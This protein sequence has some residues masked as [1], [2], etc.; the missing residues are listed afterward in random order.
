MNNCPNC[1]QSCNNGDCGCIPQGL[2]TPNYCPADLPTCPDPSPCNETFDSNC[3][4][5]TG[6]DLPC[7]N[8]STD[9]TVQ[10]AIQSIAGALE[11]FFC[12]ECIT[13]AVPANAATNVPV[14][15]AF[16][17]NMVPGATCYDVYLGTS[18]TSLTL[19]SL[20]QILTTYTHPT[21]LLEG[22][23]YYWQVVPRN[24]AGTPK[25][26]CP[27]YSFTTF[28][29]E[30]VNPMTYFLEQL[31]SLGVTPGDIGR[32]S[33]SLIAQ[34]QLLTNCNLCCPDCTETKRYVLAS[35][36]TYATYYSAVYSPSCLPPCCVE[37]DSALTTYV[38]SGL[39]TIFETI[40]P[41]T[42]CCGTNFSECSKEIKDIL[43]ADANQV[44]VDYGIV[45]ESTFNGSTT[46]CILANYLNNLPSTFTT[47]DKVDLL[48]SIL[49]G[50][51]VI[52]CRP[53]GTIITTVQGYIDYLTAVEID[54]CFCYKPCEII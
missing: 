51:L 37:I 1:K 27:I 24:D 21:P 9:D 32:L 22:T 45:E 36:S 52:D 18:S 25:E 50:G 8:I 26:D 3:V 30:C 29:F 23:V 6:I 33:S 39:P 10:Q 28:Q 2:T 19:V 49:D 14:N 44:Y 34:G 15:N 48:V 17:W 42:N 41:P 43:G 40:P 54:G 53:E 12:L 7:L 31:D 13:F 11:P 20:G 4:Y 38:T 5:Y 46:L 35:A 16:T 47:Q